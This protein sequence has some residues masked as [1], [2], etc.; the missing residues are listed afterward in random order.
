[1]HFILNDKILSSAFKLSQSECRVPPAALA[2]PS[3]ECCAVSLEV[4]IIVPT[5]SPLS[6]KRRD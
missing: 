6:G 2:V 3:S 4:G 5:I 1:M